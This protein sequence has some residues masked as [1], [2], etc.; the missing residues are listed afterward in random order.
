VQPISHLLDLLRPRAEE[1]A[2]RAG[3]QARKQEIIEKLARAIISRRLQS[4]A[5]L[6]LELN[7][8][9]GFLA[10]QAA[11]FAR[12]FLSFFLRPED[13]SAA[14]EVLADPEAFDQLLSRLS[15]PAHQET[16]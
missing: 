13:V 7:R 1:E 3:A 2:E 6:F 10:S 4:P 8:P 12:P 15:D 5:V 16:N 9:L 11:L 14:A